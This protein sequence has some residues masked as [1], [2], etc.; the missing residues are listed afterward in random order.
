MTPPDEGC[1]I[2]RDIFADSP[3]GHQGNEWLFRRI[4]IKDILSGCKHLEKNDLRAN[5]GSGTSEL[6][7]RVLCLRIDSCARQFRNSEV[8]DP[9][10]RNF[11]TVEII[12][13]PNA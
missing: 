13:P 10:P 1:R 2:P 3:P 12:S 6:A 11:K 4:S 8:P 7:G 9:E 5:Q